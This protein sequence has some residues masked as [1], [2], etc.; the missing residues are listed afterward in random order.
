MDLYILSSK[1]VQLSQV[2]LSF[3][4]FSYLEI[5]KR[6]VLATSLLGASVTPTLIFENYSIENL[7]REH[8]YWDFDQILHTVLEYLLAATE[9]LLLGLFMKYKFKLT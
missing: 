8:F 3:M 5:Q 9:T 7:S 4:N 1:S 6:H 2:P